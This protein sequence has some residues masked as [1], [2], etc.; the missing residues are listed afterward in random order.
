[1]SKRRNKSEIVFTEYFNSPKGT[2]EIK[3][4]FLESFSDIGKTHKRVDTFIEEI[5]MSEKGSNKNFI[6]TLSGRFHD[7]YIK[8]VSQIRILKMENRKLNS[9]LKNKGI[10]D[11][12]TN[13]G[14]LV[15]NSDSEGLEGGSE[16]LKLLLNEEMECFNQILL[17]FNIQF[18]ELSSNEDGLKRELSSKQKELE[19]V[20]FELN[21]YKK[22]KDI[23]VQDLQNL[24]FKLSEFKI[25]LNEEE[26][27]INNSFTPEDNISE[28]KRTF[29]ENDS[30]DIE[31]DEDYNIMLNAG[32]KEMIVKKLVFENKK[33]K[34]LIKVM[35]AEEAEY[36]SYLMQIES[37]L[38]NFNKF[39]NFMMTKVTQIEENNKKL[40]E[41]LDS[42][43]VKL[44]DIEF[45]LEVNEE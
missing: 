44:S 36:N 20:T 29:K 45:L 31:Q 22:Q 28:S 35:K 43:I 40:R 8:L 39:K 24:A 6:K 41:K 9:I 32:N 10:D 37:D 25:S 14:I 26:I 16:S 38:E 23:L 33:Y 34:S 7:L 21:D 15:L 27:N 1:M 2:K 4:L 17:D 18:N 13:K 5:S 19:K 30:V 3:D 12:S 42:V 11:I